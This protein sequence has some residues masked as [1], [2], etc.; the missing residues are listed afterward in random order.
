[1]ISGNKKIDKKS[2]SIKE[3]ADDFLWKEVKPPRRR[4]SDILF[5]LFDGII[6]AA[7]SFGDKKP[8]Q[9]SRE[10]FCKSKNC[11]PSDIRQTIY[12]LKKKKLINSVLKNNEHYFE[13]TEKGREMLRWSTIGQRKRTN[14]WDK[15][16][17]LVMFD[18]PEE[19][20]STRN[21]IRRKLLDMGFVQ[22]QKSV[23]VYPFD[24]KKDIDA[25]CYFSNSSKFIKYLVIKITEGEEELIEQFLING[26][27]SLEDLK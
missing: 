2:K 19:K 8:Y 1:M 3:K 15:S 18:V 11:R 26:I 10:E 22:M 20:K 24:C 12:D 5:N 25:L 9:V 21:V 23:F 6:D 27:L 4:V 13:L 17:R 16:F 14:K 7:V